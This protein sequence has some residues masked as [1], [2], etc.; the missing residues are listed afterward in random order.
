MT[1][2]KPYHFFVCCL[3]LGFRT[4]FAQDKPPVQFGKVTPKDFTVTANDLDSS[5]AAIV[6]ADIGNATGYTNARGRFD[7]EFQHSAR[8]RILNRTGFDAA[9]VVIPLFVSA[10]GTETVHGLKA[11]TYNLEGGQ[12]VETELDSKSIFTENISKSLVEK[13]FTFPAL[14]EGAILE[15]SYTVSSPVISLEP[16]V[17]QGKY[18]CL[19]SEYQL[20]VPDIYKYV[21][22]SQGYVPLKINS[23]DQLGHLTEY[24]WVATNIPP[25]KEEPFTTTLNNY[26]SKM[27]FQ[28]SAIQAPN[29]AY[30]DMLSNWNKITVD[31]LN[32]ES[33]GS[34]LGSRNSWLDDDL[35]AITR[36]AASDLEKAQKIYA[37]VRDSFTCTSVNSVLLNH[38]IRTVYKDRSGT[39][40]DLNLLLTAMLGHEK[41]AADPVILSTRSH[42]FANNFYPQVSRFN[43]VICCLTVGSSRYYLDATEPGLAFGRL[44]ER[45]YNGYIRILN[46]DAPSAAILS[47]DSVLERKQTIVFVSNDEKGSLLAHFQSTP[48]NSEALELRKTIKAHG[49]QE[50]VKKLQLGFSGDA[51]VSNVEL[52]SLDLPDQPLAVAYDLRLKLDAATDIYYF[53]PMLDDGYKENPFKAAKRL[54]PVE[55]PY[56]MDKSFVL[57]MEIP[58]GYVVDDMP[59]SARVM[60]NDD[61]GLFEYIISKDDQGIQFRSHIRLNKATYGPED[62]ATLRDFFALIV[63]KQTEQIVFK[64]KK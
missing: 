54:Y 4:S 21:T 38:P 32:S 37:Y 24:R 25:L 39:D 63:K 50:F 44:P 35:Q 48:G 27:E 36:G 2:L 45:C 51:T 1:I 9:N 33:F 56:A 22:L 17:F 59:K 5:A 8:I 15:Y 14:K 62:Y 34:D 10:I 30:R 19:W 6:V 11:A 16:W 43:Y 64:K 40:A 46:K 49:E 13:K 31:L 41:L 53:N 57:N 23:M 3:L 61:E 26:I 29:S 58:A 7:L 47:A 12:I 42:G 60:L 28:L 52:D 55:M 18:P 20:A